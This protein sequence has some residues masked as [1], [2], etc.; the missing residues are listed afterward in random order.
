MKHVVVTGIVKRKDGKVLIV[1]RKKD[2][3]IHGGLWVFPGGKVN[4]GENVFEALKRELKE[5]VGLDV[6]DEME[7]ISD[8]EFER[9][10]GDV[11]FGECFL[12][13][14]I[15]EKVSLGEDLENFA[16]IDKKEFANYEHIKDLDEELE[17]AFK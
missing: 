6:S 8:Y 16:W 1:K 3:E 5:E 4:E 13:K 11:T 15:S 12:V 7:R 14:P 9:P 17:R 10:N 2:E